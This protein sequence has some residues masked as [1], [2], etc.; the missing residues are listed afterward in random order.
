[1]RSMSIEFIWWIKMQIII[2]KI[3]VI[4]LFTFA[5]LW[6]FSIVKA[7]EEPLPPEETTPNVR[8]DWNNEW[9]WQW[10]H[11]KVWHIGVVGTNH[12]NATDA[13]I[14]DTI[15][16]AINRVLWMLSLVALV[17]CLWG[18]FQILTAGWDDSKVKTWTKILKNAAIWLAIIWLAWLLVAFVFRIV[19]KTSWEALS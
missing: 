3:C 12:A 1:M 8:Y 9:Y 14:I 4:A 17:L 5:I 18:W 16:N 10:F 2:K 15:K 19:G 13:K 11:K 7:D 6:Q